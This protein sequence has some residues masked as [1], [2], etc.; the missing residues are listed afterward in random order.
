M[1]VE[2]N[3]KLTLKEVWMTSETNYIVQ[4]SQFFWNFKKYDELYINDT[5]YSP[6]K[7]SPTQ[8]KFFGGVFKH[9]VLTTGRFLRVGPTLDVIPSR[10]TTQKIKGL[11]ASRSSQISI[12]PSTLG[13]SYPS[14]HN[15]GSGKWSPWRRFSHL[16][17]P[18]FPLPWLWKEGQMEDWTST[19]VTI[20]IYSPC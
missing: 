17:G 2:G 19:I 4:F 20:Y 18:H 16:P 8:I 11:A 14:S 13:T 6:F 1:D 10:A 12:M 5:S 9:C 7:I 3:S 15:H